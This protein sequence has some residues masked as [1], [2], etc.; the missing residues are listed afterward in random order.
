M[1][2][3]ISSS[4]QGP[5]SK[6][7]WKLSGKVETDGTEKVYAAHSWPAN[8]IPSKGDEHKA[9]TTVIKSIHD[10]SACSQMLQEPALHR[11]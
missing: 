5:D 9:A 6:E 7:N 3:L 11:Q 10:V 2:D 4:V 1:L 8:L